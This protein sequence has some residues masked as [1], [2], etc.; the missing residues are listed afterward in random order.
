MTGDSI[1]KEGRERI[2]V[3]CQTNDGFQ[4]A[5]KDL[6]LRGPGD[7]SGTRQ[8]GLMNFKLAN[9]VSDKNILDLAKE[10]AELLLDEDAGLD[11]ETNKPLRW[12]LQVQEGKTAWSKIS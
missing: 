1:S 7:I 2:S 5:E 3:M 9:I 4:I 11:N 10:Q 6:E 8:S 12:F